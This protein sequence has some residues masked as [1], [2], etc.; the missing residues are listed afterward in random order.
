MLTIYFKHPFTLQK[1]RS[2]PASLYL[3]DY[4][5]HL[6]QQGYS[7]DTARRHLRAAGRFSAWAESVGLTSQ[8]LGAESLEQFQGALEV[9]GSLRY[10]SGLYHNTFAGTKPFVVFLQATGRVPTCRTATP[11]A[12]LTDFVTGCETNAA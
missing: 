10:P 12:L 5:S 11:P 9:K 1:L 7:W 6:T 4:A 8:E 3:D 2:G